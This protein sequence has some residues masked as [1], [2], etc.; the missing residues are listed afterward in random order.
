MYLEEQCFRPELQSGVGAQR[1]LDRSSSQPVQ[2]TQ[3]VLGMSGTNYYSP[4]EERA[5]VLQT[6]AIANLSFFTQ[7]FEVG[8]RT[9]QLEVDPVQLLPN[10]PSL[11][12]KKHKKTS[13]PFRVQLFTQRVELLCYAG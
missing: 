13:A 6:D 4:L 8:C 5:N 7:G 12:G 2:L 11:R 3:K 1:P 10:Y 9:V